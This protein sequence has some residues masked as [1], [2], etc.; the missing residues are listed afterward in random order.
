MQALVGGALID[1]TGERITENATVLI[2][3]D[4][5]VDVG[6][7]ETITVP[8][9]CETLD[10]TGK[11]LMPGLI[12]THVHLHIGEH[13]LIIPSGGL[14]PELNQSMTFIGIKGYAHAKR[15]FEMG[16]TTLRDAGDVGYLSVALRDAIN[17]GMVEGPRIVASGQWLST[18]GGHADYLPLWLKR[19]DDASNVVDGIDQ[20][21]K[22]VRRQIKMKTDWIKLYVTGG[23][24]DPEDKQ[25]FTDAELKTAIEEAHGKGKYVMG[26]C[27]HARGTLAGL[28]AGLDTIEHGTDLTEEIVELMLQKGACLIPTIAVQTAIVNRGREFGLPQTYVE[29][30]TAHVEQGRKSFALAL[31]AGVPIALGTD[32]GFNVMLHG[33]NAR[34][35]EAL[36]EY[37]MTPMQAIVSATSQAASALRLDDK[38]GTVER[39]KQAD[40]L[41]VNGNPSVDVRILQDSNNILMVMKE[42]TIYKNSCK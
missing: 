2:D 19:T 27:M 5:I 34:E 24:M 36:A 42:G 39:G 13:D 7:R 11:T 28:K 17:M 35:L 9:S 20:V 25:E 1:G 16:F 32:A 14:P 37:G 15:A 26:H 30:F 12:D 22:A 21:L 29:R 38:I 31:E 18:T 8:A 41:V 23:I 10:I 6:P 33:E 4:T 3:K 40:L